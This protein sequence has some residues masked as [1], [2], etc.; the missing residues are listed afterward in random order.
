MHCDSYMCAEAFN[1]KIQKKYDLYEPLKI[2][3]VH[4]IKILLEH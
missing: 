3:M 1:L 2:T 4:Q